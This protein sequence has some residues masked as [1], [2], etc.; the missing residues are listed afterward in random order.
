MVASRMMGLAEH[1]ER[2]G[3]MRNAYGILLGKPEGKGQLGR[4]GHSWGYYIKIYVREVLLKG[5]IKGSSE[6]GNKRS[7]SIKDGSFL[8]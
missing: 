6:D 5:P 8:K 3:E 1:V 2:M 7:D 4:S